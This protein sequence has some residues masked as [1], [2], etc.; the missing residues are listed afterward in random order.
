MT[1]AELITYLDTG[2][3]M[4]D[5]EALDLVQLGRLEGLLYHWHSLSE[6]MIASRM[7]AQADEASE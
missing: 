6:A 3:S 2:L 5:L 1:T 7:Q 4:A